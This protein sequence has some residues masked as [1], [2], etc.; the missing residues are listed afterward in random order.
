MPT[1]EVEGRTVQKDLSPAEIDAMSQEMWPRLLRIKAAWLAAA[2]MSQE[3]GAAGF[4]VACVD[5]QGPPS[6]AEH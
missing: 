5:V 6:V 2:G 3:A 1:V 4:K